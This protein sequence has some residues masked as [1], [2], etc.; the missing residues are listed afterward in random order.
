[1]ARL[2]RS[3]ACSVLAGW[4]GSSPVTPTRAMARD[5]RDLAGAV[6][7]QPAQRPHAAGRL[8]AEEEVPPDRQQRGDG[9][10]LPDRGDA[11]RAGLARRAEAHRLAR[12]AAAALVVPAAARTAR[13]TSVD[14]PEPFSPSTQVISPAGSVALTRDSAATLPYRTV[15]R[16]SSSSAR[17]GAPAVGHERG[18]AFSRR[19][20][21][22]LASSATSSSTPSRAWNQRRVPAGQRDALPGDGVEQRA[23]RGADRRAVAAGEQAA[24]D[25]GD[26]DEVDARCPG[27]GAPTCTPAEP[28]QPQRADQPARRRGEAEQGDRRPAHRDAELAGGPAGAAAGED[29]VA[30][31]GPPQRPGGQR[32][33]RQPPQQRDPEAAVA[34][35][36]GGAEHRGGRRPAGAPRP[37]RP[38]GPTRP[39][40]SPPASDV[41]C[42]TRNV[43]R[44]TRK[45]GSPVLTTSKPLTRPTSRARGERGQQRRPGAQPAVL[46]QQRG[47][48]RAGDGDDADGQVEL[49]GD[50][51]QGDGDRRRCRAGPRCPGRWPGRRR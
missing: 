17:R 27:P 33:D 7:V 5:G 21:T 31:A 34:D 42:S 28:D 23:D 39:T 13:A 43:A 29:G 18:T 36:Q 11:G 12:P 47:D 19:R 24:A 1:M 30:E 4:S 40:A 2:C 41:P 45:L 35:L 14:L 8:G 22:P 32:R 9:E 37:A 6:E 38:P 51:Q 26:D 50:Q 3:P 25:D 10:V 48:Q 15:S 44:V 20:T 46:D 49:A 16:R